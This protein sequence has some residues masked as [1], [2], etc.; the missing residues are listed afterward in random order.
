MIGAAR[1]LAGDDQ[2]G[3]PRP[4]PQFS[5]TVKSDTHNAALAIWKRAIP[6]GDMLA[7]TIRA[8]GACSGGVR[9]RWASEFNAGVI[10]G[11]R[12]ESTF[13]GQIACQFVEKNFVQVT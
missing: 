3:A 9:C 12:D 10:A 11:S 8:F 1:L 13:P 7:E 4:Q 2:S 5:A 6:A